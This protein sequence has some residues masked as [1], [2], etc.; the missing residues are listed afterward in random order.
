MS[1]FLHTPFLLQGVTIGAPGAE[2]RGG[3]ALR[4]RRRRGQRP[5]HLNWTTCSAVKLLD[6]CLRP[7]MSRSW[8]Q[9]LLSMRQ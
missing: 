2:P 5:V 1:Y 9:L 7:G 8:L 4:Q 3:V 6:V